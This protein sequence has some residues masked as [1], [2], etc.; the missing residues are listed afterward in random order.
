[1]RLHPRPLIS[2]VRYDVFPNADASL[3]VLSE[4][5]QQLRLPTLNFHLIGT[6][7][8]PEMK[9]DSRVLYPD[10]HY[11]RWE[12]DGTSVRAGWTEVV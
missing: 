10:F 6:A 9:K 11:A 2:L 8:L 1:M 3:R 7:P 4:R 12:D 5:P